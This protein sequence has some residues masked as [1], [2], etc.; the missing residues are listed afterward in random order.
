MKYVYEP[1]K[2]YL[3]LWELDQDGLTAER[4][5]GWAWGDWGTNTDMRLI[6]AAWHYLALKSAIQL[7]QLNNKQ[8]DIAG[9]ESRM[10]SIASAF[11]R[12]WNGFAYRHPSYQGA[13]DDRVQAM[14]VLTGIADS[15]KYDQI[16]KLFES[17]EYASPYMGKICT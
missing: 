1:V 16:F 3:G 17:Q 11:N 13:T 10:D 4:K 12:C 15:S 8:E 9:Y 7:A 5:G 2:R 14:A 6:L